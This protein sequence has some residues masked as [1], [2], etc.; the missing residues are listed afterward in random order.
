MHIYKPD[1]IVCGLWYLVNKL[2]ASFSAALDSCKSSQVAVVGGTGEDG[3]LRAVELHSWNV[4]SC[5]R[6]YYS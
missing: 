5:R 4:E 2:L 3:V 1:D 6:K